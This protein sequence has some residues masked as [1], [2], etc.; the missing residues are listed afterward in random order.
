MEIFSLS[1][2]LD[3][4]RPE[5]SGPDWGTVLNWE[6]GEFTTTVHAEERRCYTHTQDLLIS[7][8]STVTCGQALTLIRVEVNNGKPQAFELHGN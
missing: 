8:P 7:S 5:T 6:L 2:Q 1:F 3:K 4:G